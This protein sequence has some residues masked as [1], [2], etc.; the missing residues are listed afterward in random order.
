MVIAF[1]ETQK[2][3]SSIIYLRLVWSNSEKF[4]KRS[5]CLEHVLKIRQGNAAATIDE[6]D[7]V[8]SGTLTK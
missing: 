4:N 5:D 2:H 7:N 6:E 1:A 3:Q 8:I